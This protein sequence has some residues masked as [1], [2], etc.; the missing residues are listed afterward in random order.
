MSDLQAL[1]T[2]T[3]AITLAERV[4]VTQWK[5]YYRGCYCGDV[6]DLQQAA[7]VAVLEY[8]NSQPDRESLLE[9]EVLK[10]VRRATKAEVK[11]M[12]ATTGIEETAT[13][14]AKSGNLGDGDG[15]IEANVIDPE[16]EA[17]SEEEIAKLER[18]RSAMMTVGKHV[19]TELL[20][21][22]YGHPDCYTEAAKVNRQLVRWEGEEQDHF[23]KRRR[24]YPQTKEA[25]QT[26][27]DNAM[28]K[29]RTRLSQETLDEFFKKPVN[30]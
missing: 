27:M 22:F 8:A 18:I 7:V 17:R 20:L 1:L 21:E 28:V 16:M 19:G 6:G 23:Y 10:T 3:D 5:R 4:A 24:P 13:E 2:L 11:M 26:A 14:L 15:G 30:Q 25:A 12:P 29:I 9:S